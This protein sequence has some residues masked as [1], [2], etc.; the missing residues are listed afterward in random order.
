MPRVIAI[1]RIDG[2]R[3]AS[4]RSLVNLFLHSQTAAA[5]WFLLSRATAPSE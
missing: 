5:L 1:A 3:D 2:V 4:S